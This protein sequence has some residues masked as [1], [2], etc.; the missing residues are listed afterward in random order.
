MASI[1]PDNGTLGEDTF[2]SHPFTWVLVPVC[3]LGLVAILIACFRFKR[4]QKRTSYALSRASFGRNALD[5]D[6]EALGVNRPRRQQNGVIGGRR[7]M[8]FG[9]GDASR[10]EGLNELGEAPPAYTPSHKKV[11]DDGDHANPTA[12]PLSATTNQT[13]QQTSGLIPIT[14][15]TL[16]TPPAYDGSPQ[17]RNMASQTATSTIQEPSPPAPAVLLSR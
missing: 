4:R 13:S 1:S 11:G 14:G 6:L 8:G 7:I 16:P 15:T 9:F 2:A 12:W 3:I 5:Q 17:S 10:E